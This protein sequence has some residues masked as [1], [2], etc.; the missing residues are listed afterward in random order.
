VR[1]EGLGKLKKKSHLTGTRARDLPACSI[2]PQ[3]TT[4]QTTYNYYYYYYYYRFVLMELLLLL[5][6]LLLWL[7]LLLLLLLLLS[8]F[9]SLYALMCFPPVLAFN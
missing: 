5:L 8:L 3:P 7:L 4:I 6:L 1:L 2:V 9:V